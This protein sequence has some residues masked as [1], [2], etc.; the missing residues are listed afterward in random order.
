[1][2]F[3]R[4]WSTCSWEKFVIWCCWM[5]FPVNAFKSTLYNMVLSPMLS[6]WFQSAWSTHCWKCVLDSLR[7]IS[8]FNSVNI[9]FKYLVA[10]ML[11]A[12][13]LQMLHPLVGLIPL[14]LYNDICL[15]LVFVLKY[16]LSVII[17]YSCFALVS[18]CIDYLFPTIHSQLKWISLGSV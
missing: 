17:C 13:Y 1:M 9:Y 18:I 16:V 6:Y 12:Q 11:D 5:E 10:P 15:L 2:I 4:E 3:P 14:S 7:S 8:P